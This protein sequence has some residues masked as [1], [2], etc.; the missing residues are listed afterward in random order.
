MPVIVDH[1]TKKKESDEIKL[2]PLPRYA[3]ILHNDDLH[4]MEEVVLLLIEIFH[5][6]VKKA[7]RLMLEAHFKGRSTVL[8]TLFERAELYRDK[9]RSKTLISTIERLD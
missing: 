1:P 7:T 3:V 9:L 4:S 6:K 2:E 5:Y 8:V